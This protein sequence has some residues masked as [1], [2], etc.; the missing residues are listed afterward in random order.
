MRGSSDRAE[1]VRVRQEQVAVA[2]LQQLA[3]HAGGGERR[4]DVAVP[5]RRPLECGVGGPLDRLEVVGAQLRHL[6]LD[7]VERQVVD[8]QLGVALERRERVVAGG[9]AV[10]QQQRD[11]RAVALAQVQH[12]AHDHVEEG[13]PVLDLDQRLGPRHPHAGA[14]PAV[15]LQH[16][17]LV[18]RAAPSASGSS[19]A[20]GRSVERLDLRLA[21]HAL[22][23][24]LAGA[25]RSGRRS[26]P[27]SRAAPPRASS[28][29]PRSRARSYAL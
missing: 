11:A 20:S 26:R 23:A 2:A 6:A 28:P 25:A 22:V 4:V 16:D 12:L 7:E 9:E 8:R 24:L 27:R 1:V 14:E 15:E 5:R 10:H 13:E 17:R 21:D 29:S 3:E 19:A 18:E